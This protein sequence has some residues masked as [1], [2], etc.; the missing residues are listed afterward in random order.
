MNRDE[1][2]Y[3]LRACRRDGKDAGD[4]NTAEALKQAKKDM[5]TCRYKLKVPEEWMISDIDK[6][7]GEIECK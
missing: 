5:Q 1:V 2:K 4:P 7:L 3:I 6:K